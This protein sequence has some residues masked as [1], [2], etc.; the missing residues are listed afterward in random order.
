L[1][2]GYALELSLEMAA[3]IVKQAINALAVDVIISSLGKRWR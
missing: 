3:V 2:K 1:F